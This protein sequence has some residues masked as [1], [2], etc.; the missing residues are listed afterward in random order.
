M[1]AGIRG[2][3]GDFITH[4]LAPVIYQE[5]LSQNWQHFLVVIVLAFNAAIYASLFLKSKRHAGKET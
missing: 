1:R 4:Y 5:G 3:G 2:Y